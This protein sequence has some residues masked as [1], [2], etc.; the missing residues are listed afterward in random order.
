MKRTR[1]V[2]KLLQ[3]SKYDV[4]RVL[5]RMVNEK[6]RQL[7]RKVFKKEGTLFDHGL[8]REDEGKGREDT[9]VSYLT[10]KSIRP[11]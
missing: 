7:W 10:R 5:I 6:K 4:T 11:L 3:K 8:D 1:S 9:N 2:G